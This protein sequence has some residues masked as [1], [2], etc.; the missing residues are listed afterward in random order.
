MINPNVLEEAFQSFSK[1]PSKWIHDGIIQVDMKLLNELGLLN[2]AELEQSVS[3]AHLNHYFHIIETPEKV[4]LFNEQFA[5]WI[6]PELVEETPTTTTLIAL[7]QSN[8]PHLEIVYVTSGVYNTPKYILKILQ[9]FLA[10][11][12][13]TEAVISSIGKKK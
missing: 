9:H 5:I 1:D 6:V 13:D 3:D 4:T 12:Q 11:V 8:K 10:E 2:N 7:L